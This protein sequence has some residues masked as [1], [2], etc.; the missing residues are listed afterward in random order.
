MIYRDNIRANKQQ[1]LASCGES[2]CRGKWGKRSNHGVKGVLKAMNKT[3][4]ERLQ[5]VSQHFILDYFIHVIYP[6]Q[7][8]NFAKVQYCALLNW[9]KGQ[10]L[11]SGFKL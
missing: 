3:W 1:L 7:E 6:Y 9:L 2:F 4:H 5:Q 10:P 8:Y 11:P